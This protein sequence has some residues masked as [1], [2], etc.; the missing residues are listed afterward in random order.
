[1][2]AATAIPART[3]RAVSVV[4]GALVAGAVGHHLGGGDVPVEGSA[5]AA[6]LMGGPAWMLCARERRVFG[7][8]LFLVLG[9]TLTHEVLSAASAGLKATVIDHDAAAGTNHVSMLLFHLMAGLVVAGWLRLGEQRLW[10]TVRRAAT[11]VRRCVIAL[12]AMVSAL[13]F[14]SANAVCTNFTSI[15]DGRRLAALRHSLVLRGPPVRV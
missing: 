9:Q 5:W 4:A 6:L 3:F 15:V 14:P 8:A 2:A 10:R 13:E 7:I 12:L 11:A 1:M